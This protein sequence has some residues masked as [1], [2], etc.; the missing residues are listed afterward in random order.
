MTTASPKEDRRLKTDDAPSTTHRSPVVEYPP[1]AIRRINEL[2][3][4]LAQ[5][6]T[7]LADQRVAMAVTANEHRRALDIVDPRTIA[8]DELRAAIKASPKYA[9]Y[10]P[11][12]QEFIF[13]VARLTGLNPVFELHYFENR[14]ELILTPDY[15]ALERRARDRYPHLMVR[16]RQLSPQEM[17]DRGIPQQDI[18]EGSIAVE[19]QITNLVDAF[20]AKLAGV[21]YTPWRGV[22]WAAAK[23]D[24]EEWVKGATGKSYKKKTGR[25]VAADV[26]HTRDLYFRAWTRAIRAAFY[27]IADLGI[28]MNVTIPGGTRDQDEFHFDLDARLES[29]VTAQLGAGQGDDRAAWVQNPDTVAAFEAWF[30]KHGIEQDVFNHW[31]GHDW[32]STTLDEQAMRAKI[33]QFVA[34]PPPP[35]DDTL[36]REGEESA[37][38]GQVSMHD[39][40]GSCVVSRVTVQSVI[41]ASPRLTIYALDPTGAEDPLPVI[42]GSYKTE[43]VR[44]WFPDAPK[45]I[46]PDETMLFEHGGDVLL[47][48]DW[49]RNDDGEAHITAVHRD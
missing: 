19:V 25:R 17:R 28:D 13:N 42:S 18:D 23:K 33:A 30:A 1:E 35:D 31:L 48:I 26:P 44:E 47:V 11:D 16:D 4:A 6:N 27:Q 36:E 14:G 38:P 8:A 22:A 34:N 5:V 41:G 43:Q 21:E 32:H 45:P 12:A 40:E 9:R 39:R 20:L 2:E 15:K 10:A 37:S 49:Q 24:E 29:A 3:A 46:P 7:E